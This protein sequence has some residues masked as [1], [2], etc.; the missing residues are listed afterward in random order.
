MCKIHDSTGSSMSRRSF[1]L[2]TL[3]GVS[4]IP[5]VAGAAEIGALCIACIDYRLPD[6]D[7]Y[8]FDGTA[9]RQNYDL[10]ALAGA[11][12]AGSSKG[13]FA[14]TV[15]GFWQQVDSA[16]LLHKIKRVIVLDH[17]Q[18]G[19]YKEEFSPDKP[20]PPAI[21]K[22]LHIDSMTALKNQFLTRNWGPPGPPPGGIE[23]FLAEPP[24]PPQPNVRL[25][26][27]PTPTIAR[28]PI[29]VATSSGATPAA[30]TA[31]RRPPR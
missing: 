29:N 25:E 27:T 1:A 28:I 4:F 7:I 11:S 3:A 30:A 13:L 23:F 16:R 18:C 26:V 19:A 5:G 17:M 15:P 8:F 9:G 12:L 22:Q 20:L 10:V 6:S 24:A 21:E 2:M 31:G 14:P